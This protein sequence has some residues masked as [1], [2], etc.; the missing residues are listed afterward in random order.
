MISCSMDSGE[1]R[2]KRR[3]GYIFACLLLNDEGTEEK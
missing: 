3:G 2:M 1:W